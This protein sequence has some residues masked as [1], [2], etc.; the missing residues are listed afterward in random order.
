[1][2]DISATKNNQLI[3][4]PSNKSLLSIS[5]VLSEDSGHSD[6]QLIEN[7]E[8]SEY[9]E[10]ITV[11]NSLT[12]DKLEVKDSTDVHIGNKYHCASVNVYEA[13]PCKY[14]LV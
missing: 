4:V 13:G 1:M 7:G 6:N 3:R 2:A 11:S 8:P 10:P 12:F 14:F 9:S 5:T